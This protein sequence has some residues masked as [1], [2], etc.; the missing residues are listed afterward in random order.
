MKKQKNVPELRFPEFSKDWTYTVLRKV[1]KYIKGFAFRSE[2]YIEEGSRIIRVSDLD[3]QHINQKNQKVYIS[4]NLAESD[5]IIRYKIYKGNIIIT[6]VGSKPELRA[7]AV[8]RGIYVVN[9]NE[10]FLNQNL[11]KFENIEGI[12]NRLALVQP[13]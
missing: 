11:L 8:G 2:D 13:D 4:K 12:N 3:E 7:S 5:K 9:D 10:G 1:T 6:T